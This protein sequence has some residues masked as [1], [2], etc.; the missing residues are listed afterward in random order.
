MPIGPKTLGRKAVLQV[1]TMIPGGKTF[2]EAL[3]QTVIDQI[4]EPDSE[5]VAAGEAEIALALPANTKKAY[6]KDLARVVWRVMLARVT[7]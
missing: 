7:T 1:N 6:R 5:M 2:A 3:V 4:A